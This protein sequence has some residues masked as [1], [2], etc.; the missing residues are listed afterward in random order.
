M[1]FCILYHP[2]NGNTKI[3]RDFRI[4]SFLQSGKLESE[5]KVQNAQKYE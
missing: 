3:Y 4:E 2:K 5:K 1:V